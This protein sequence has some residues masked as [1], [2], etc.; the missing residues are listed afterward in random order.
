M[1]TAATSPVHGST[2][3]DRIFNFSAGPAVLPESVLREAQADVWN[4]DGSG[5]GILE[6]SHRGAVVN[7][8]FEEAETDCRRLAG[9]GDEYHVLFLQ[10]GATMQFIMVPMNYLGSGATADYLDTGTWTTKAIKEAKRFGNVNLAFDGK[11][12][13][14][15]H[16]PSDAGEISLTA[17]AAYTWY[18]SNNTIF[19]TEYATTPET[20]TPLICDASSDIFSRP[21]DTSRHAMVFAGAQKNLGPSGC[22]LV[23]VRKDFL[24]AAGGDVPSMLDYAKHA[25]QGS[26][27]NTPP[28]FA[29]YMMGRVFKWILEQGGLDAM[30][31]HNRDKAAILYDVIDGSGGFYQ[32]V[33]DADSRSLM[34]VTFR[35][36]DE[37][38]DKR[39]VEEAG[40]ERMSGLKGHRSA[41]GLRASIYNAFPRAGCETLA[42]FMKTFASANG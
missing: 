3:G 24:E 35:T 5:I 15:R 23:I 36:P 33:A 4:I 11:A 17:D 18:C 37:T 1:T 42:S 9:V 10:G 25:D 22:A 26:R 20:A 6:H 16:V 30:A 38:I 31:K 40:R 27:L 8:V 7:R 19:G 21:L 41:G 34:N 2:A 13:D 12:C 32:P 39:F 29:V 28:V 14:Y